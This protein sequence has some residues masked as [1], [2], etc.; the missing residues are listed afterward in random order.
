MNRFDWVNANTVDQAL[1]SVTDESAFKA[2]GVDLL[3][4]MKD[5]I[6][7]PS[8][9]V[10]IRQISG[11]DQISE[12]DKGLRIGPLATLTQIEE[13]PA[14]LK[15]YAALSEAASRIATP[16]I[17][18]M[19]TVGGNLVQRPRC[20]YFRS[21]DFHCRKKGGTHCFAQDGEN[22]YHAIF[23]NRVCAIIHP[24]GI[25]VPLVAMNGR[26]EITTKKGKR[27]VALEEF[28][29][30]PTRDVHH[31]NILEPGELITAI[32]V[33][34]TDARTAYYKQG[35]K[36][37]FDWPIADVAVALSMQGSRCSR[38]SIVLGGAAP[39]PYRAKAAEAKLNNSE[40]T[41]DSARAAA[42]SA[43]ANAM[44]LEK[45]AYKIPIFEAIV[46]R[47][48]LRAAGMKA[49]GVAA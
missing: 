1:A 14:I 2:G 8:R 11:L 16:Q 29:I 3:D 40:I 35:E 10:N 19:A 15:K 26:V 49:E 41:E 28:F 44:P 20:W 17:R 9:L 47:T 6:A 39:Y 21:E 25:A 24:S 23:D 18:N 33:P 13:H 48:I 5:G 46:R 12:D 37:S 38:A 22:D 27:E 7:S 34:S 4:L 31:E 42:E 30:S 43:M 32:L 45:N 36:E